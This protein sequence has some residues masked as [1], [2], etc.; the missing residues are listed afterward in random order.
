[1][2][3]E[4]RRKQELNG[5]IFYQVWVDN[6]IQESFYAGIVQDPM[7]PTNEQQA[8]RLAQVVFDRIKENTGEKIEVIQSEEI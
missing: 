2:K 5:K 6:T 7:A 3:L 1:M 4:L 8:K